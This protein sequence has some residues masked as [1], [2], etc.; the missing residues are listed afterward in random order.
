M[1]INT[2]SI[3]ILVKAPLQEVWDILVDWKSQ[4]SWMLST[5]VWLDSE[6]DTG[7]GVKISALTGIGKFGILDSMEVTSWKPPYLCEV[8]HTGK[9]IKGDGK[10]ELRSKSDDITEFYWE[11]TIRAPRLFFLLIKPF[12]WLGV[13]I[14]LYRFTRLC[15]KL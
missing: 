8:L 9:I 15:E 7:V 13:R 12:I 5:K 14:S 4:G 6:I 3:K 10:F 1:A 11:E 2:V